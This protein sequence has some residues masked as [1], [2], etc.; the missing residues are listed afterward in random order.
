MTFTVD[1]D[2]AGYKPEDAVQLRQRLLEGA[3][4]LPDVESA[5]A[6]VRGLMRGTGLKATVVWA[7]ERARPADFLNSSVQG[8]SPEYFAT[9]RIPWIAGRNFTGREDFK[10]LPKPVIVN[11]AF[12]RR[13]GG[14]VVGRKFGSAPVNGDPPKLH[15]EIIGVVGDAKYRSL[16]EPFQPIVYQMLV[17]DQGF[18]VHLRTR[19]APETVIAPM[20]KLLTE[21]EPRLSYIEVTTLAGEVTAS[22]W[23]ERVAAFLAT[24]LSAA[25]ALIAAA[26]LYALLAFAVMQR[27]REIGIRVALG[28]LPID[29]MRLIFER[30]A[31]LA[32]AGIVAG[33]AAA[34]AIA[35]RIAGVLYEVEPRDARAL[36]AAAIFVFA[37]AS[38]AALIPSFRASRIHPASVLRQE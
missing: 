14:D 13:F 22:L 38:V 32:I 23:A 33:L 26:G 31:L 3:R 11:Q 16:R 6:A 35:P 7:G 10:Q 25:A 1:P 15:F 2:M 4:A 19:A 27:R 12:V 29:V 8:V 36:G 9:M 28:A 17:P 30:A 37:V 5:A 34:W 24:A 21:L 18:I 20:R